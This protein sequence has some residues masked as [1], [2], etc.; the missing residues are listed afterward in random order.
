MSRTSPLDS[1]AREPRKRDEHNLRARL[2]QV[3]DPF[4]LFESLFV[5]SPVPYLLFG[6]D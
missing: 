1:S 5:Q 3:A 2:G 6:G 4:A